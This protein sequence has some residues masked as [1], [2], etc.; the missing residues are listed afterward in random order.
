MRLILN[1]CKRELKFM[2]DNSVDSI[3]C[4]PPYEINWMNKKWD[5][6]GIAYDIEMWTE[7]L[8]V[9]KPGGHLV[10]FGATRTHHR[11]M[12]AIEDAGFEIRECLMWLYFTGFPKSHNLSKGIDKKLGTFTE[13][14]ETANSRKGSK[15]VDGNYNHSKRITESNP[16]SSEAKQWLGWGTALKPAYEPIVLA[17]KPLAEKTITEN[18]LKYGTGG[19]NI[20]DCRIVEGRFPSNMII[21]EEVGEM[22]DIQA[23]NTVGSRFFYCPKPTKKEKNEGMEN[24]THTTIKPIK[25]M[26]YLIKLITPNNGIVLDPFMGSGTTGIAAIKNDFDFIGIEIDKES[27]DIANRRITYHQGK[28]E[29]D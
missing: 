23:P 4:D 10:A 27:Y 8:R 12:V 5:G 9:L 2:K 11:M 3:V 15:G 25:L 7:A 6:T 17:R 19:L 18:V 28:Y 13:G 21:D 29:K 14:K 20:E 22:I 24:N 16:Q 26:E 1:D